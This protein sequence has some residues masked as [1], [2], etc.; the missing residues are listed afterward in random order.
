MKALLNVDKSTLNRCLTWRQALCCCINRET[1]L[2]THTLSCVHKHTHIHTNT[3]TQNTHTHTTVDTSRLISASRLTPHH[4]VSLSRPQ[5]E[6]ER[7]TL[8]THTHTH[9]QTH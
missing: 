1:Q 6:R 7:R 4:T 9:T 3:H 5:P 2:R 8:K